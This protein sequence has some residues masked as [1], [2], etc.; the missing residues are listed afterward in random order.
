MIFRSYQ[1]YYHPSMKVTFDSIWLE[2]TEAS[3]TTTVMQLWS[4]LFTL[5]SYWYRFHWSKMQC[6]G[7]QLWWLFFLGWIHCC[8]FRGYLREVNK[9]YYWIDHVDCLDDHIDLFTKV[10]LRLQLNKYSH[11][12][13]KERKSSFTT[14]QH[15]LIKLKQ[16]MH[17]IVPKKKAKII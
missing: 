4:Y 17:P 7:H 12:H 3:L 14:S 16:S 2:F 11:G 5:C 15:L 8:N 9:E 1:L 13:K 6:K 10:L